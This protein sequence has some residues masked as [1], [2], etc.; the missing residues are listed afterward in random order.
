MQ[1]V[2]I[3][4]DLMPT[5]QNYTLIRNR[6]REIAGEEGMHWS[7]LESVWIIRTSHYAKEIF[8]MLSSYVDDNDKLLVLDLDDEG[9]WKGFNEKESKFL[10]DFIR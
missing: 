5:N 4:Y 9:A 2:L 1:N 6:I 3:T 10:R 8:E 7:K